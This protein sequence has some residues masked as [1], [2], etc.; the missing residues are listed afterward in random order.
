MRIHRLE[1]QAFGPF[2]DRVV[3]DLDAASAAGLF[4]VHGPTGSGK[5]SL[6]D[7]VCFALYADVPGSRSRRSLRSDHA[8]PGTAPVVVLEVTV[9]G[10]RLRLTRSPEWHRP[11]KRGD[12]TTRVQPSV[13]LE[14]RRGGTWEGL[15][16]RHDE[17]AD[18]VKDL[19]GMGLQQFATVV[20]L[21]Q[22]RFATFLRAEPEERRELLQRLF[23]IGVYADVE[24]WLADARRDGAAEL[25]AARA[26]LDHDLV[27]LSDALEPLAAGDDPE[28]AGPPVAET[29]LDLLPARLD[30]VAADVATRLTTSL[31]ALDTAETVET[32]AQQALTEARAVAALRRRGE[33]AR[34]RIAV[35]DTEALTHEALRDRLAA[36]DRAAALRGH[37][38]ALE[39]L[40]REVAEHTETV[41]RRAARL[42]ALEVTTGEAP[43]AE[44]A[45]RTSALDDAA[46]AIGR[47]AAVARDLAAAL[48]EGTARR[49]H[50]EERRARLADALPVARAAAEAAAEAVT[51]LTA[52]GSRT[53]DLA[54][55]VVEQERRV[56]LLDEVDAD[57]ARVAA[58]D[59]ELVR[60]REHLSSALAALIGL[61]QRRLDEMAA[62]LAGGLA[63]GA[64]CP[65]CGAREHP[66]PAVAADPVTPEALAAADEMVAVA[67]A[68]VAALESR[69]AALGSAVGARLEVLAGAERT[70]L[71]AAL[72]D[73]RAALESA[74]EAERRLTEADAEQVRT[75]AEA[76]RVAAAL[77]Q[78]VTA[79]TALDERTAE[80]AAQAEEVRGRLEA[81]LAAHADCP[82]ASSD[83]ARHV[84]VRRAL[85]ELA[86]AE[87]A[88]DAARERHA[89]AEQALI[90]ALDDS[91]FP[92]AAAASA[93]LLSVS[94]TDRLRDEVLSHDRDRATALATLAEPD[95]AA[96]LAA[97]PPDLAA[98]EQAHAEARRAVLA[99][100]SGH[101]A[102]VRAGRA[103]ERLRP[104]L[105]EHVAGVVALADRH[106]RVRELADTVGGTGGDN[107]LRMRLTSFVLAARLEK[108]AALANERLAVMGAGRYLLEHTD[109][110]AA[111]GARSGL[112]LRVLDQWTGRVRDTA[113]LSGGESFMASLALALGLADAVRDEAGGLD[114]GTLFV[115][116]G[117][118]S[119]DDDS[120][121]QVVSVLD[122]LREGGR[123]VGVVSHV[124]DL[125]ARI[126]HQVVVTKGTAGSDVEV[127]AGDAA[128][129]A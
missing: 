56:A 8:A 96:A 119:L 46:A 124:A 23:D 35:L 127:R 52:E 45:D 105:A 118:G 69:R 62:E 75:R 18:V 55:S 111:R 116:E 129:A 7:A 57:R 110:R 42:D 71:V 117:F 19:L 40:D 44:L 86:A 33:Q 100:T 4:L 16:T 85:T 121:E 15:S 90:A 95:V 83:P 80:V 108:V 3:V 70:D 104:R 106:D 17:V 30:A 123:A 25:E 9:A 72:A 21:P 36:A 89:E 53:D 22:G 94:E 76:D 82:C 5:T 92:S 6:L 87:T 66:S 67:R 12:G 1:V 28:A 65:V 34:D 109:D 41:V 39:R 10:R 103:V 26:A 43:A 73:A 107:T 59:P 50:L 102:L 27:R 11:K 29:P 14:E 74:R 48:E 37:L 32:G 77:E 84:T 58:L 99:G 60:A 38:A 126:G 98:L 13:L 120:L 101:D 54:A 61:Q 31:A 64:P 97:D 2:A 113:T 91:G 79:A 114:L 115:D 24:Q 88:L 20:L 128:P 47:D 81:G 112:G 51:R 93:A 63:D 122:G 49:V 68:E 125:R 78:A